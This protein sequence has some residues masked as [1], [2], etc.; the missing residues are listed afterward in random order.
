VIA[1]GLDVLFCGINPSLWS[2]AVGHHFAHP[3]NRFWKVLHGAGFTDRLLSPADEAQLL[4]A[5]LGVTNLVEPATRSAKDV[6]SSELENGAGALASKVRR[7]RPA[8]VAVVGVQAYRLGFRRPKAMVGAQPETLA[9]SG[10][11]VLPNPSGLQ[12]H[13]QLDALVEA[14]G[15]LRRA[16]AGGGPAPEA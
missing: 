4:A 10:L 13:Y 3:S 8:Y 2:A 12:A 14:F 11:W 9:C 7:Y 6:R 1:P 5:G 16:A 15:E